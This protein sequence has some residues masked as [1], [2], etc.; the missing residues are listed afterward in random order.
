MYK[1]ILPHSFY[2]RDTIT[3]A[4][5]LLGKIIVREWHPSSPW[6]T[7]GLRGTILAGMIVETEAY[8]YQDDPA[9]HT[10]KGKSVRNAAMFG[11]VGHAYIYF[12]YGN[13][14]C[15]DVVAR[16]N[17]VI[18]GGV[19]VRAI[20]PVQGIEIMHQLRGVKNMQHLGNGPGKLA[21]AMAISKEH[22]H[23][24]LM[25]QGSL[26]LTEGKVVNDDEI[27]ATPR[28]GISKAT[29]KLWRFCVRGNEHV[30]KWF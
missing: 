23:H 28:I 30:S 20:E 8:G 19:L 14:Y 2:C 21:Q 9:S 18:A 1:N 25:Q 11:P 7:P 12:I 3:V 26:Y 6:A 4:R 5:E 27:V 17:D 13:H 16:P 29:D 22:D 10:Y 24:N 15:F